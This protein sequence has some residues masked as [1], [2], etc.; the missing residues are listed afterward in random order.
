MDIRDVSKPRG[1]ISPKSVTEADRSRLQV[2]QPEETTALVSSSGDKEDAVMQQ[3][4]EYL[5]RHGVS[6]DDIL[7]VLAALVSGGVVKWQFNLYEKIPVG[8][9]IRP[10]WVN[11]YVIREIDR[12]S[13]EI[14]GGM[15]MARVHS[16]VAMHN[17]AGS[18]TRYQERDWEIT[19]PEDLEKNLTFVRGLPYVIQASLVDQLAVFDRCV[20]VATSD[21][22]V[23]NFTTPRKDT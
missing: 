2:T 11:D 18:L 19:S 23:K 16:I 21:W 9:S 17:L 12:A 10:A 20:A 15:S 3:F 6:D 13:S 14:P 4:R 7:R 8:F 1:I 22:A 5:T